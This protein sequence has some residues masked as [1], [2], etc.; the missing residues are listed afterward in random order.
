MASSFSIR[1]RPSRTAVLYLVCFS[2]PFF[3]VRGSAQSSSV[4]PAA[5]TGPYSVQKDE[6]GKYWFVDSAGRRF[7][8][9]GINN[10]N[11]E[12]FRPRPNTQYYNPVPTLFKGD[13]NAWKQEVLQLL[14]DHGFT[15]IGAWSDGRLY[16]GPIPGTICLY[17]A[18]HGSDRCLDA[19]RPDFE[20]RVLQNIQTVL[21]RYP[22]RN[23]LLGVFLDNE[24]PW[25]GHAPWGEIPNSTLLEAALALP[26]EDAAHQAAVKFLRQRYSSADN[27][28]KAWGKPLDSWDNLTADYARSCLSPAAHQDRQAFIGYAADAFFRISTQIVRQMMPGVLILGTRFAAYAPQ[29]AV[30]T[31]GRYCD[32]IS[33][34]DYRAAPAA[35]PDM[36]ARYWIWGGQKPLLITEYS[37]RAEENTSGNP[38][39]GGAGAVVKTQAQRAENYQKYVE[40]L[41][42]YPIVIGA[43]WFEF[44]DQSPQGRFDGENSNYGIV[45]IY[46]RRY[47]ELLAAMKQTN[48]RIAEIHAKSPKT[49]PTEFPKPKKVRLE[50]AQRPERP[51]FINLL[52]AEPL[53]K[54]ELFQAPDAS[55]QLEIL[56]QNQGVQILLQTGRDWGCGLLLFGPKEAKRTQGPDFASDLDGYS[57]VELDTEIPQALA[58][59]C[60]IDEAGVDRP[61]AASYDTCAGDDAESFIFPLTH[62]S[63]T[64]KIYRLNLTELEPRTA[65][66]NQKGAGR[67][68]LFALKGIG[69]YFPG[70]QGSHTVKLYALKLV[71]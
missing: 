31:C 53:K 46:H 51:P 39:T 66:G 70:S 15:T 43:H 8:S 16:D 65:W 34:N 69:L 47:T 60:F 2:L 17:V 29:P 40:D 56:A 52:H 45:D 64:R 50:I 13:F 62:G 36:I 44:A 30:E 25:Y 28:A 33:F 6:N 48:T 20:K 12:P 57:A 32:V 27:L 54:P 21:D 68:D 38:N 10:I 41:L 4:N 26:K 3:P 11:A 9:L 7:L 59:Q 42:S 58:F 49:A 19:L 24:M 37:W 14:R 18:A 67:V 61:D 1:Q 55:I 63:G 35:D 22:H 23:N 5:L 71:R